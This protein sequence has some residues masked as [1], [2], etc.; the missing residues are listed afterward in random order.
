MKLGLL[1]K[2]I[3]YSFSQKYFNDKFK[4]LGLK[5]YSYEIFD[6]QDKDSLEQLF[7]IPK[8]N[9]FN[10]T[11]PYKQDIVEY[12]DELSPEAHKIGAVNTVLIAQGKKIGFNTDAIGFKNSLSPLLEPHHHSALILGSGGASKAVSYVLN[13]LGIKSKIISRN[14]ENNYFKLNENM[15][16]S[17]PLI[18]NTTPLGTFPNIDHIPSFPT[19]FLTPNHL[20]Y[21]LIYNPE[22]TKLLQLAKEKGAKTKNGLEMLHLQA[23]AAW[24]IW[25]SMF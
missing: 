10:V 14:G 19:E 5:D 7:T 3:S 18:I 24:D 23:E 2:N 12:L 16:F 8:L 25:N 13:Q 22:E 17:H 15:V 1:G 9:G 6:I 21:D 4:V 11:I 20:V